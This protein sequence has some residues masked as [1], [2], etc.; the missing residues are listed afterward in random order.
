MEI[1]SVEKIISAD[2][3][4]DRIKTIERIDPIK[5]K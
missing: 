2:E 4:L 1:N 3:E 5:Y